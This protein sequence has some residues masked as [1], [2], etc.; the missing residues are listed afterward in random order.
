MPI[1]STRGNLHRGGFISFDVNGS[2]SRRAGNAA[3]AV[4]WQTAAASEATAEPLEEVVVTGS[5]IVR[6]DYAANS[7]RELDRSAFGAELDRARNGA[8][9]A[10]AVR[11][12]P[13]G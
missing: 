7:L 2:L 11:S 8:E 3:P 6:R 4:G 13:Q 12:C 5:R 9:R 1:S 10:A